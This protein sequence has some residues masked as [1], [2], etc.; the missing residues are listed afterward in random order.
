MI[1]LTYLQM[2]RLSEVWNV[3]SGGEENQY[4]DVVDKL[5]P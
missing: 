2:I 1:Y 5:G 3:V 4:F